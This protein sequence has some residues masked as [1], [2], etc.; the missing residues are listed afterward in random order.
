MCSSPKSSSSRRRHTKKSSTSQADYDAYASMLRRASAIYE[1][2]EQ[3]H[4][5]AVKSTS[6]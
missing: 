6:V 5:E 4:E 2:K 1:R 3:Q